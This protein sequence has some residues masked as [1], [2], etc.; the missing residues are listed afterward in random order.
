MAFDSCAVSRGA[1]TLQQAEQEPAGTAAVETQSLRDA[2]SSALRQ[3]EPAAGVLLPSKQ[4]CNGCDGCADPRGAAKC[5]KRAVQDAVQYYL[6]GCTPEEEPAAYCTARQVSLTTADATDWLTRLAALQ[7]QTTIAASW[8]ACDTTWQ[9][10]RRRKRPPP[11]ARLVRAEPAGCRPCSRRSRT[12][13]C[14]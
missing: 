3:P 13:W 6:A 11:S 12:S 5:N 7:T 14:A 9:A 4:Q 2:D 1:A 8:M 10:A